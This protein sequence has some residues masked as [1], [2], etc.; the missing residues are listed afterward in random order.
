MPPP[1]STALSPSTTS[2]PINYLFLASTTFLIPQPPI[3][4]ISSPYQLALPCINSF[5]PASTTSFPYQI[6]LSRITNHPLATSTTSTPHLLPLPRITISWPHQPP[7]PRINCLF[8]ASTA[9]CL[10]QQPLPRIHRFIPASSPQFVDV[11]FALTRK[12]T[13]NAN[14]R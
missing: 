4:H 14:G 10:H 8:P 6:P 7:L 2:F 3:P 1:L 11:S 12:K 5:F 13:L 9:L